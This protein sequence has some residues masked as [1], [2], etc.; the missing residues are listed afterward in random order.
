MPDLLG[1]ALDE[2]DL[3]HW[4]ALVL[5]D[6]AP[7]VQVMEHMVVGED[8]KET[9]TQHCEPLWWLQIAAGGSIWSRERY[10]VP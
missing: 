3:R 10:G 9:G 6:C 7:E 2:D 8:L 1:S 4:N 5:L